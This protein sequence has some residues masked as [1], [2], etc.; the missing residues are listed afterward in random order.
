VVAVKV[1]PAETAADPTRLVRL[2]QEARALAALDHP[3]IVTLLSVEEDDGVHFLTMTLVEGKTLTRLIPAGGM[4]LDT[5]FDIA[6]PLAEALTAAHAKGL[7]HR[8]LKPSNVMVNDAG[9]VKMLD[10][11]LAKL[12]DA[13]RG[14]ETATMGITQEG[15]V[16]GTPSYMSPEQLEND[17][18]D[19]RVSGKSAPALMSSILKDTPLSVTELRDELP[20]HLGRVVSRCLAK[21]PDQRFQTARDVAN[22]LV[23]LRDEVCSASISRPRV[24]ATPQPEASEERSVAVLPFVNRSPNP[25]D[26]YFS[27]GLSE[28]LIS[29]LSK[30]E[31]LKVT[32]RSSAFQFRGR[33]VDVRD[34]GRKLGVETVLEGSVRVAGNRLRITAQLVDCSNG[35][36]LWSQRYDGEMKDVFDTQDEIAQA[37]T[38]A[39]RVELGSGSDVRLVK[40]G[41]A[42]ADA[43]HL[44]LRGRRSYL[45]ALG[46]SGIVPALDCFTRALERDPSFALA[47]ASVAECQLVRS[48][49]GTVPGSKGLPL[50][51]QAAERAL[52]LDDGLPEA[53]MAMGACYTN[54]DHDWERAERAYRR[55]LELGPQ[56]A[57]IHFFYACYLSVVRRHDEAIASMR[58]ACELDPLSDFMNAHLP[59]LLF[60]A[61]NLDEAEREAERCVELFPECWFVPYARAW[62]AWT[63]RDAE[64]TLSLFQRAID[65]SGAALIEAF[66][67]AARF[68]FGRVEEAQAVLASLE[69]RQ[70]VPPAGYA[71]IH[72]AADNTDEAIRWIERARDEHDATFVYIRVATEAAN[73]VQDDRVTAAMERVGLP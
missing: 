10:F 67:I 20:N 12:I 16:V 47:H 13:R 70:A 68:T 6:I 61:G 26:E 22:E 19:H 73:L 5:F 42:D 69:R 65:Q 15:A 62:N 48:I 51:R 1:L 18:V 60:F 72:T 59:L 52:A 27:D 23:Q 8:D 4:P 58:R 66:A 45:G 29:A 34:V 36:Q 31:D 46:E 43:Y 56:T 33:E 39:L 44:Y 41:T 28:E 54:Y 40:R 9:I 14:D 57:W 30:L 37:I 17:A 25:D 50:A 3:N 55:A 32:A 38:G 11:G 35:Y 7:I 71:F 21:N 49:F 53:H 2:Q 24:A 63:R 64:T